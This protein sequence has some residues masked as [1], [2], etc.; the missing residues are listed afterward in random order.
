M[1]TEQLMAA[2]SAQANM[3]VN[4]KCAEAGQVTLGE[5]LAHLE[6][7]EP[8][9]IVEFDSGKSPGEFMSY[10]GYYRFIAITCSDLPKTAGAFANAV[11]AAI[12]KTYT[13]YKGGDFLMTKHTPVWVS[14]YGSSSGIGI[15]GIEK[16]G[17]KI[18]LKTAVIDD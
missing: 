3:Q 12:G 11:K 6:S 15:V 4:T 2:V 17:P 14:E 1:D 8:E 7:A 10:R 5:L 18:I 9:V 16:Q 13:G